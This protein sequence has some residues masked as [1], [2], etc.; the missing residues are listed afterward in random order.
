MPN[1][2]SLS[3]DRL[4]WYERP[5][6]RYTSYPP[7]TA[8]IPYDSPSRY[9]ALLADA[10][11]T[12]PSNIS[13]YFHIPFC[14]HRCLFCGCHTEIG[15]P[16]SR[17][18]AYMD[19]IGK[20]MEA[21][22]KCV[23]PRR[24]VTQ[25]HFGGG[26][27]NAIP[28]PVLRKFLGRVRRQWFIAPNAEIAIECDPSLL[29]P[30]RVIALAGMGFNRISLGIQD[31]RP[32]VLAA[33]ERR[34]PAHPIAE[35][36]S[37]AHGSGIGS[38][39]L[40]LIYGLPLQTPESFEATLETAIETG[41]DRISAFGYAHVPWVK[42]HQSALERYPMPD[43]ATRLNIARASRRFFRENGFEPIGMDHFVRKEDELARAKAASELHR[44]F[45][46]YCSLRHTGQVYAFGA[47]AISQFTHGYGQNRKDLDGY[48]EAVDKGE[49]PLSKVYYMNARDIMVRA[50]IDSLMCYGRLDFAELLED[51]EGNPG[52]L[53]DYIRYSRSQME[54]LIEDGWVE[55]ENG[56]LR[57]TE[58]G[59]P[60]VRHAAAALDPV[61]AG[62]VGQRFSKAI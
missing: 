50:A 51:T 41:A 47:S 52:A 44:N 2:Q 37:A 53:G 5:A 24:Q 62:T 25:I 3:A 4:A 29:D 59:W 21:M 32:Q 48:L 49:S 14:P 38:V 13:L 9:A 39:N 33:V 27:P 36:V 10:D 43:A 19:G 55:W 23:D 57:L 42:G 31:F 35:L 8:F 26:T 34:L 54:P 56:I 40:D 16:G 7:A 18:L 6:P 20:E 22:A 15:T 45:Q 60:F 28:M 11:G 17:V 1:N 58:E 12:E 46:G 61:S 30:D